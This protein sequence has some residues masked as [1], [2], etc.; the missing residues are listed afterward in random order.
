MKKGEHELPAPRFQRLERV[1]VKGDTPRSK[2]FAGERGIVA[3][4]ESSAVRKS[5]YSA[6]R[7]AYVVYLPRL[8]MWPTFFQ[9]ELESFGE[10]ATETALLGTRPE[11]S[12]DLVFDE[13]GRCDW[14][15]GCYRLPGEF[16]KVAIFTGSDVAEVRVEP[17]RWQR[18]SAWEGSIDGIVVHFPRGARLSREDLVE[19]LSLGLGDHN[20]THVSGPDSMMLR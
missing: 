2:E 16:W 7:W 4:L 13:D 14:M 18:A 15:E 10:F 5:P 11:I 12:F 20:W 19:A 17:S 8:E 1:V 6:D 3:W 9:S